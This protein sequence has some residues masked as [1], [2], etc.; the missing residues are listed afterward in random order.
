MGSCPR[1]KIL[2]GEG[3]VAAVVDSGSQVTMVTE[4]CYE[5]FLSASSRLE[6]TGIA[7]F[8][9]TAANGLSIPLLG[10]LVADI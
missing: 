8:K 2:I 3:E 7:S 1:E 9:L 5:Q 10:Y 4:R 6:S